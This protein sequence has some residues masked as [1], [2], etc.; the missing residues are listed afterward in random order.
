MPTVR[1]DD[2]NMYYEV[3]GE[4]EPIVLICGLGNDIS[5]YQGMI[6]WLSKKYRV[7]AFD[8]RGAGRTDKPDVPYTVEV[9]AD[10]TA[11]LMDA[12][13]IEQ[14]HILS[15][16]LGGRIA[17]ALALK[18]PGRV[19]SLALV[20]TFAK[21]IDRMNLTQ[22]LFFSLF[23]V[24]VLNRVLTGQHPQPYYAMVRQRDAGLAFDCTDRLGEIRTPTITMHGRSDRLAPY[25]M[26]EEMHAGTG[27]SQMLTFKGG[28]LFFMQRTREF[29]LALSSFLDHQP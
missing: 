29:A 2:I 27:G 16:S 19:R 23:K 6:S 13:G 20:S 14:A 17:L 25:R 10:D 5:P 22:R 21:R 18:Y 4:G 9:M 1:V 7:L 24:P 8:N 28:H 3:R 15:F 26:A 12:L 11:G